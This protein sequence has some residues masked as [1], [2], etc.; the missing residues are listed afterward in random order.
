MY[1]LGNDYLSYKPDIVFFSNRQKGYDLIIKSAKKGNV[2]AIKHLVDMW[3]ILDQPQTAYWLKYGVGYDQ[4]WCAEELSRAYEF[5][6]YG[7]KRDPAKRAEYQA[8]GDRLR[9]EGK[10]DKWDH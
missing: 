4:P 3:Q 6:L 7:L 2:H 5:G 1:N 8:I 9:A 10:G